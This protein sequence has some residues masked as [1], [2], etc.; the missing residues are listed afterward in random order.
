MV[1]TTTTAVTP[2][3]TS[4][5]NKKKGV[6]RLDGYKNAPDS[7]T[8][9]DAQKA[10]YQKYGTLTGYAA[11]AP[12]PT[13]TPTDP[14]GGGATT[15]PDG[16][17]GLSQVVPANPVGNTQM[18]VVD[19]SGQLA[20]DPES[21]MSAGMLLSDDVPTFSA[22]QIAAGTVEDQP[23]MDPNQFANQ[24]QTVQDVGQVAAVDPREAVDYEAATTLDQ[25]EQNDMT[26]ATGT[27]SQQSQMVAPQ[28]DTEAT[29]KGENEVGKALNMAAILD[30][31]DVDSRAT[32][33]GQLE[34]LQ[35]E[36]TDDEGN[37]IVPSWASGLARQ[38]S[39]IAAFKGITGTAAT[40]AMA[41][42]LL[43]SSIV[44]AE[45]DAKF[46]QTVTL[47]NLNNRQQQTIN[48]ANVLAQMDLANLDARTTAAVENAKNFMAMDMANLDNEQQARLV[49]TQQ[50]FQSILEDSKA[51]NAARLFGADS[52]NEMSR[53]YDT[54]NSQLAEFNA[55]Q[56]N[57]MQMFNAGEVNA[58]AQ[59]NSTL[60]DSRDKFYREMA[61]NI[62]LSN[63]EWRRTIATTETQMQFEAAA[64]DAKNMVDI[65]QEALNQ[66]WD[67]SD[68]LLDY[69]W[70]S[71]ENQMDRDQAMAIAKL[72]SKTSKSI[73]KMQIEGQQDA[74]NSAGFGQVLG[75]V[76]GA[77]LGPLSA[78]WF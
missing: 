64:F 35:D 76:A 52:S 10:Y 18:S 58:M 77:I 41:N 39:R 29:G 38:V 19:Y 1:T 78:K 49:N 5:Y 26:A 33:K 59:F 45:Q 65:S 62:D 6:Y 42:A 75:T 16:G 50:R 11:P 21:G 13:P 36:F 69:I 61:Y 31:N 30:L 27:V 48:K 28:I 25:V 68:A 22:D 46:F 56:W 12:T 70:K 23:A 4:S 53:F 3:P 37:P 43:E 2:D 15:I 44:I 57:S 73:A 55:S 74:A 54:L 63:A 47:T 20:H 17:V 71:A 14:T 34:I 51:I 60:A 9:T 72:Q 24:A 67:R 66:L 8:W 40:E 32:L 7:S